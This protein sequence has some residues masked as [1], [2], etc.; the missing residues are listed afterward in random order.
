MN[1]QLLYQEDSTKLEFDA[2]VVEILSLLNGRRGVVLDQSYFYPTG[3]GQE[4]DTGQ[5]GSARVME[6]YKDEGTSNLVHVVEGE[7]KLGPVRACINAE[8][9]LRHMQHHTAQHLLT[10]CLLRQTGYETVSA[11]IK[12]YSSSP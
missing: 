11:N 12:G 2:K 10:Q 3:G 9:R 8:R 4:H 7:V 1:S 6:V 5:L